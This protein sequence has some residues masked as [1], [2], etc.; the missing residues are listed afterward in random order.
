MNKQKNL[1]FFVSSKDYLK[2]NTNF[3]TLSDTLFDSKLIIII[4]N[5]G[6]LFVFND[7]SKSLVSYLS[8]NPGESINDIEISLI[9]SLP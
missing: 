2:Y 9:L 1:T 8:L 6:S 5:K 4:A 7:L 3:Y